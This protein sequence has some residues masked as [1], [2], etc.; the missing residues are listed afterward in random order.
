MLI[1][2]LL[3]EI[4]IIHYIP[5][6]NIIIKY[7]YFLLYFISGSVSEMTLIYYNNLKENQKP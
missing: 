4:I 6:I 3:I 5:V 2:F 7:I 1:Y